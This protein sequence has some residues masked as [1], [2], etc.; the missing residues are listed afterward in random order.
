MKIK[1][2]PKTA[3]LTNVSSVVGQFTK[4]FH[5]YVHIS[6]IRYFSYKV[7]E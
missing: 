1:M 3:F 2:T 7:K 4:M 5:V 6:T